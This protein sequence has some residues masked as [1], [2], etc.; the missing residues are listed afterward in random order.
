MLV[1]LDIMQLLVKVERANHRLKDKLDTARAVEETLCDQIS[2]LEAQTTAEQ[3][4]SRYVFSHSFDLLPRFSDCS[5]VSA[6]SPNPQRE[7]FPHYHYPSH[8]H[9]ASR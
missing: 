5:M 7:Q 9:F 8:P 4:H 6:S 1:A 2:I 3:G